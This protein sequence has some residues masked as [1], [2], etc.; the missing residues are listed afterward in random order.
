LSTIRGAGAVPDWAKVVT[1]IIGLGGY[2]ATVIAT[3]L[4]GKIPDI[5]TLGIPAALILALAPPVRIG[6]RRAVRAGAAAPGDDRPAGEG[7]SE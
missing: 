5:G 2:S 1:L 6:R 3:L 7:D 4:Q